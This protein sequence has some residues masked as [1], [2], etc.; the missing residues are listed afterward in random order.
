M[1][2]SIHNISL[3]PY[4]EIFHKRTTWEKESLLF[5]LRMKVNPRD[6]PRDLV[7][8]DVV[9]ALEAGAAD[10][11]H[12]I[13]R[14]EELLLPPHE[15]VLPLRHV[16]IPKIRLP[17]RLGEG[18]EGREALPVLHVRLLR[19]APT[20]VPCHETVLRADNLAVEVGR[21][22]WVLGGQACGSVLG[23]VR[24]TEW[25]VGWKGELCGWRRTV[26]AQ[27]AADGGLEQVDV[28]DFDFDAVDLL[29]GLLLADEAAAVTQEGGGGVREDLD[30]VSNVIL[31]R[32]YFVKKSSVVCC[33]PLGLRILSCQ[34]SKKLQ[35][36]RG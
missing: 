28:L 3:C 14:H 7:E 4:A 18:P 2:V 6:G 17:R 23:G 32:R 27:V 36:G 34:S 8:A 35:I 21:K 1:L 29:V 31:C 33:I 10:L 26:D 22:R 20:R 11:P 12:P 13:I 25:V 30:I 15:H 9:E 5:A 24:R 16:R 19:R